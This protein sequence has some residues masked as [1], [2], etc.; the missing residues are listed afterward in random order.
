MCFSMIPEESSIWEKQDCG[1]LTLE[2]VFIG[3]QVQLSYLSSTGFRL[4]CFIPS[5]VIWSSKDCILESSVT[6][7]IWQ[8]WAVCHVT[9]DSPSTV[10]L[11]P[12]QGHYLWFLLL[13]PPNRVVLDFFAGQCSIWHK[14]NRLA[15]RKDKKNLKKESVCSNPTG[16]KL[17]I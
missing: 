12:H 13:L 16:H 1:Q 14:Y 11:L 3:K 6:R 15:C 7:K 5:R 9:E 2:Y 10:Y 8:T 17:Y 4:N